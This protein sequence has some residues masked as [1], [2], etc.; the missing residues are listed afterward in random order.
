MKKSPLLLLLV[1]CKIGP[2]MSLYGEI[3]PDMVKWVLR[4]IP[5]FFWWLGRSESRRE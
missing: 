2:D 3:G 1:A 5:P 4:F